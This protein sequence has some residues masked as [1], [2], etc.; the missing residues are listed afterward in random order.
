[1]LLTMV[2]MGINQCLCLH[3]FLVEELIACTQ[4]SF[5]KVILSSSVSEEQMRLSS[6]LQILLSEF[7]RASKLT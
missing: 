4:V 2:I 7:K 6:S 3:L 5:D 1:M